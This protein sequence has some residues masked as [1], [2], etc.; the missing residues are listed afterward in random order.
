M[1]LI[2]ISPANEFF[3]AEGGNEYH[4]HHRSS[5]RRSCNG[6]VGRQAYGLPQRNGYGDLAVRLPP[7]SQ[8]RGMS[9][10][11]AIRGIRFMFF[12]QIRLV[13][14]GALSLPKVLYFLNRYLSFFAMIFCNYRQ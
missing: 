7:H 12:L 8:G 13:W 9:D 14:P 11:F 2:L 1:L 4:N 6:G 3:L 5:T 10:L